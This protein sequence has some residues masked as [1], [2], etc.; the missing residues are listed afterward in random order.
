[1]KIACLDFEGVLVLEIWINI[2]KQTGIKTLRATA[3]DV[4]DYDVN[5]SATAH[6]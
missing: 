5:E 1:M 2:S 4:P 6:L 3:R